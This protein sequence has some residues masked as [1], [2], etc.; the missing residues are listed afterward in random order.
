MLKI[1]KAN[2]FT[3]KNRKYWYIRYQV[4]EDNE[5]TKHEIS[6]KIYLNEKSREYMK[7]S[8]LPIWIQS[9]EKSENE[10]KKH[11]TTLLYYTNL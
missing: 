5:L 8:F 7:E 4:L 3:K 6:S 1:V 9:K 2:I 10:K 11:S